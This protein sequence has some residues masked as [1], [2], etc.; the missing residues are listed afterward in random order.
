MGSEIYLRIGLH[1]TFVVSGVL[2]AL[3]DRISSG[4]E[5]VP[6]DV[7]PSHEKHRSGEAAVSMNH[8]PAE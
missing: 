6:G 5:A 3:M 1:L 2:F 8:K 4:H 7:S